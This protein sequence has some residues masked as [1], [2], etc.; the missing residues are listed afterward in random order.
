MNSRLKNL[1]LKQKKNLNNCSE[2]SLTE[3]EAQMYV[4]G[5]EQAIDDAIKIIKQNPGIWS[6]LICIPKINELKNEQ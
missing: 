1:A 3:E 5:Y 6:D 4:A 2:S